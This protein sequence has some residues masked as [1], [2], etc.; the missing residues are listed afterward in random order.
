MAYPDQ[1]TRG[2][3]FPLPSVRLDH[4]VAGPGAPRVSGLT[5]PWERPDLG[6][7]TPM[8]QGKSLIGLTDVTYPWSLPPTK[9]SQWY[10]STGS[11]GYPF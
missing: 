3:R 5:A 9:G 4:G 1:D 10:Y 8:G 7:T 11:P 2:K 6:S